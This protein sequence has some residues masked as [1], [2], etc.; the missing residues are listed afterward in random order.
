MRRTKIMAIPARCCLSPGRS[1][2][3]R[4]IPMVRDLRFAWEEMPQQ[5]LDEQQQ[6]VRDSLRAALHQLG[7]RRRAKAAITP[8]ISRRNACIRSATGTRSPTC[9]AT[10]CWRTCWPNARNCSI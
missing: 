5:L 10:A 2:G 3:L 1:I 4:M 9:C 8:T 6:K 7:A